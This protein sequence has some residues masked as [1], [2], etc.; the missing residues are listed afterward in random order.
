MAWKFEKNFFH[1]MENFHS[2]RRGAGPSTIDGLDGGDAIVPKFNAHTVVFLAPLH[3]DPDPVI[4]HSA[5]SVGIIDAYASIRPLPLVEAANGDIGPHF[6][7]SVGGSPSVLTVRRTQSD[8]DSFL[9]VSEVNFALA[10]VFPNFGRQR[11]ERFGIGPNAGLWGRAASDGQ[12]HD[13]QQA[14]GDSF[15]AGYFSTQSR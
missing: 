4:D 6:G 5:S 2:A 15:H 14:E 10:Y 13:G 11:L 1:A 12:H 3:V 9:G 7:L 8:A